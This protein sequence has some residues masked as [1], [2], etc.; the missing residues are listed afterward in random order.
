MLYFHIGTGC[1]NAAQA[2]RV[3]REQQFQ[4]RYQTHL[5]DNRHLLQCTTLIVVVIN[6]NVFGYLYVTKLYNGNLHEYTGYRSRD[7]HTRTYNIIMWTLLG[8]EKRKRHRV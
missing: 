6:D 4:N 2:H 7:V 8:R 5:I 1:S 3:V